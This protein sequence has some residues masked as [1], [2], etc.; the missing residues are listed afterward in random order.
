MIYNIC[1]DILDAGVENVYLFMD[2]KFWM[3]ENNISRY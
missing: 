1:D 2:L 3:I